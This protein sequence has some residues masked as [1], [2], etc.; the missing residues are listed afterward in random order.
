MSRR[1][2]KSRTP[3][4]PS[5]KRLPA[6]TDARLAVW[7]AK[8]PASRPVHDL[9]ALDGFLTAL[10]IGPRFV[11]LPEWIGEL[12]GDHAF[13][14][15]AT[16][17]EAAAMQAIVARYNHLALT[18]NDNPELYQPLLARRAEGSPKGGAPDAGSFDAGPWAMGFIAAIKPRTE[19]WRD[20][21][22]I[23]G[24]EHGLLAPLYLHGAHDFGMLSELGFKTDALLK[25]TCGLIK[26]MVLTIRE[27]WMPKR[28][29]DFHARSVKY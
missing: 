18:L 21:F 25:E 26:P 11:G 14:A 24:V 9:S 28:I 12:L 7:L 15:D 10:V 29:V 16:T 8:A 13:H 22:D 27:F 17:P 2:P 23:E 5:D 6:M 20:L 3:G 19:D 4:R 1:P